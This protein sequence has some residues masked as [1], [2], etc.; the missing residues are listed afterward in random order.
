M[1]TA[2]L[3]SLVSR[4]SF[5]PQHRPLL[6]AVWV[7]QRRCRLHQL[8]PVTMG[9]L[10]EVCPSQFLPPGKERR[11]TRSIL[12]GMKRT[13][14]HGL[15]PS[16]ARR[17]RPSRKLG[18]MVAP[19]LEEVLRTTWMGIIAGTRRTPSNQIAR[20]LPVGLSKVPSGKLVHQDHVVESLFT[21]AFLALSPRSG[22]GSERSL[23]ISA[24][25]RVRV[26]HGLVSRY[27]LVT[28][29]ERRS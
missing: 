7:S 19:P 29:G 10:R 15:S 12:V 5:N 18:A 13:W 20:S 25:W 28:A 23:A 6:R 2:C 26:G 22:P 3:T 4:S 16:P 1:M 27:P 9:R 24:R 21:S 11:R 8:T 14:R 17:T